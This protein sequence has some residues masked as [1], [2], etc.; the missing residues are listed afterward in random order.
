LKSDALDDGKAG[1][2]V[3]V[4]TID[5]GDRRS[6][7]STVVPLSVDFPQAF[8]DAL[9]VPPVK[10]QDLTIDIQFVNG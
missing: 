4:Y 1:F 10:I 6:D 5:T 8:V 2:Q 9:T 7:G 3:A